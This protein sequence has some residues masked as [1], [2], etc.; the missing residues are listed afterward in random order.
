MNATA[1]ARKIIIAFSV[2]FA[3]MI[4][5][6]YVYLSYRNTLAE[7]QR[8]LE[9]IKL[10]QEEEAAT[11]AQKE[12]ELIELRAYLDEQQKLEKAKQDAERNNPTYSPVENQYTPPKEQ[13]TVNPDGSVDIENKYSKPEPPAPPEV[14][15][16]QKKDPNSKPE[17][18]SDEKEDSTD[19]KPENPPTEQNKPS[20]PDKPTGGNTNSKGEIYVPGFG[21]MPP[22]A[23]V[24]SDT[25]ENAGKGQVIGK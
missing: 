2:A 5:V 9:L 22:P 21:W 6:G 8:A 25:A 16:D 12:K 14:P 24:I 20:E 11:K 17:Y 4:A 13:V 19:N 7:Q 23:G 18:P 1:K 3:L 10:Q 15:E